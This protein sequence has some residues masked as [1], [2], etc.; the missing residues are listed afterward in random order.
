MHLNPYRGL[1]P[2]LADYAPLGLEAPE[3]V[4]GLTAF[5]TR[6]RPLGA[7]CDGTYTRVYILRWQNTPPRARCF[8]STLSHK[9]KW[10]FHE[11]WPPCNAAFS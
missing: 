6:L 5:A 7:G 2:S 3:T 8:G 4:P 1:D 11:A 9:R 10:G